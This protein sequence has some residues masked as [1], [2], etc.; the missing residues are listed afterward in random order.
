[1]KREDIK[2]DFTKNT[3]NHTMQVLHDEGVYRHLRF[4]N[5]G[6]MIYQFDL[7]TWPGYLCISG[8]MGTYVF[9]RV[10]DMFD[11]FIMKDN[12]F[13]QKNIINPG[14]WG[15]KLQATDGCDGLSY[16]EFSKEKFD[17]SIKE[18]FEM[19]RDSYIGDDDEIPEA[20][21]EDEQTVAQAMDELWEALEDDVLSADDNA[22]RCYD[23]ATD[24]KWKSDDGKLEFDMQ[25]FWEYDHTEY[26]FHYI[27]ILYAI[28]WGI[29]EYT[30]ANEKPVP[31]DTSIIAP[32]FDTT[33]ESFPPTEIKA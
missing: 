6:S 8:D 14:Y 15:E 22:V 19:F 23:A 26:T 4:S 29:G 2:S 12:D 3:K 28:V 33:T 20:Y 17:A 32:E 9:S 25:D 13:N 27:W 11:F 18:E 31:P 16:K 24:F 1:M 7:T 30:K 5:N 21:A 10:H